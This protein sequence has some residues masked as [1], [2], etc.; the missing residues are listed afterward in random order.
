[1]FIPALIHR[2]GDAL[3]RGTGGAT[4][5]PRSPGRAPQ[6]QPSLLD[7]ESGA[8]YVEYVALTLL[9]AFGAAAAIVAVG[10]PLL[11]SFRMT[12]AFIGAPVP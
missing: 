5:R 11:E 3:Q 7:D 6:R 10:V 12:Q 2:L 8:V 9:V 1:M 4:G